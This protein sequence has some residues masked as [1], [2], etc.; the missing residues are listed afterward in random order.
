MSLGGPENLVLE[1]GGH[2]KCPES[3]W[4]PEL[5]SVSECPVR[6]RESSRFSSREGFDLGTQ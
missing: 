4:T 5:A 6:K 1:L 2:E 3:Y